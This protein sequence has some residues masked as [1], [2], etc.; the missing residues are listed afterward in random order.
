MI[1]VIKDSA[2]SSRHGIGES[3]ADPTNRPARRALIWRLVR[4]TVAEAFRFRV[5]GLAA[6]AAFFALLSLPPLLLGL[7]ATLGYFREQ[8]GEQTISDIR[9]W[10]IVNSGAVLSEPTVQTVVIPIFDDVVRGGRADILSVSFLI[11][12]WSG[13]RALN[14]YVDTIT[15]A[16]GLAGYRGIVRTRLLSFGLYLV[17]LCAGVVLVPL[18]VAGPTL[19]RRALPEAIGYI[20]VLYW[21][22]VALLSVALLTSLYHASV[23]VRTSWSRDLPGAVVAMLIWVLGSFALRLYL[24]ASLPGLSLYGS[25]AAPIA[26]LGWLFVTALAVLIGAALNAEV[27]RIWPT[28][29]TAE[30]RAKHPNVPPDRDQIAVRAGER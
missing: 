24:G 10:L 19:V 28:D 7:V 17:G 6:E 14:V 9:G 23:P 26:V 22:V 13:S 3:A 21:P 2:D 30:T 25:L 11:S 27:D 8:V 15:I 5:T 1:S 16:Y 12:L 4:R 29:V 20:N 18:V